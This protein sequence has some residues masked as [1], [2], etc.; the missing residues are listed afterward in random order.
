[1]VDYNSDALSD[2]SMIT[3]P[4]VYGELPDCM[5]VDPPET[6][7]EELFDVSDLWNPNPTTPV[8]LPDILSPQSNCA[9]SVSDGV[10]HRTPLTDVTNTITPS[11]LTEAAYTAKRLT[12]DA[13]MVATQLL[14]AIL[15]GI[16]ELENGKVVKRKR[17][18]SVGGGG[19]GTKKKVT[20]DAEGNVVAVEKKPRAPRKQKK[21]K[22][23]QVNSNQ[24]PPPPPPYAPATVAPAAAVPPSSDGPLCRR[25]TGTISPISPMLGL[26]Q[27]Q[28]PKEN[29]IGRS[30]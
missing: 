19:G 29:L 17:S 24:P 13:E 4:G 5:I 6:L 15:A 14:M 11:T 2:V 25:E 22:E 8:V 10:T 26:T 18:I 30:G 23:E 7:L 1:M 3:N 9:S 21:C 16:G 28:W 27:F 12:E 20:L